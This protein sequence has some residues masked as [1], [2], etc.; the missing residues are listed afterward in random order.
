MQTPVEYTY[1]GRNY[2][3]RQMGYSDYKEYLSSALWSRIRSLVL[4]GSPECVA[5]SRPADQV[6]HTAYD[7]NTLE[8]RTLECLVPVCQACH[9]SA[10]F[11]SSGE[12]RPLTGA[13]EALA[14]ICRSNLKDYSRLIVSRKFSAFTSKT[15]KKPKPRRAEKPQVKKKRKKCPKEGRYRCSHCQQSVKH[16]N[17]KKKPSRCPKCYRRDALVRIGDL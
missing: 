5:C 15:P 16:R 2:N 6:H 7:R 4:F 8:G 12:K 3:L 14:T 9:H 11:Y 17:R 1:A 13:N 10:E